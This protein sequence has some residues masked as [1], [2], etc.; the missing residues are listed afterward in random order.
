MRR[1]FLRIIEIIRRRERDGSRAILGI[2]K[3]QVDL[4]GLQAGITILCDQPLEA[5]LVLQH[6][7]CGR[8]MGRTACANTWLQREKHLFTAIGP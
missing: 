4:E 8:Y 7:H 2:A 6:F 1:L 3:V 5:G